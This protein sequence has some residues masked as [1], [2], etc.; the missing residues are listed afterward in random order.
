MA[1]NYNGTGKN[2]K[3]YRQDPS[4]GPPHPFKDLR[5]LLDFK[6]QQKEQEEQ[7][8]GPHTRANPPPADP[9]SLLRDK[10]RGDGP[11]VSQQKRN[12]APQRRG[13]RGR[14]SFRRRGGYGPRYMQGGSDYHQQEKFLTYNIKVELSTETGQR[15]Y[16]LGDIN[17]T[18]QSNE[19]NTPGTQNINRENAYQ[20]QN[21]RGYSRNRGG[22]RGPRRGQGSY[23]GVYYYRGQNRKYTPKN[24]QTDTSEA[25]SKTDNERMTNRP[26]TTVPPE[27]YEEENWDNDDVAVKNVN[28]SSNCT[29]KDDNSKKK[30]CVDKSE[31]EYIEGQEEYSSQEGQYLDDQEYVEGQGEYTSEDGQY[32]DGQGYPEGE[33]EGEIYYEDEY[34]TDGNYYEESENISKTDDRPDDSKKKENENEDSK[35][36][37]T[38]TKDNDK[39]DV[40]KQLEKNDTDSKIKQNIANQAV[41]EPAGNSKSKNVNDQG[42]LASKTQTGNTPNI[43]N[44]D[45]KQNSETKGVGNDDTILKV[46]DTNKSSS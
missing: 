42:K 17:P 20:F 15:K 27:L 19:N 35:D 36:T 2:G 40:D 45:D 23:R 5:E 32:I 6:K 21:K 38:V 33:G 44:D 34:G 13:S 30:E 39:A 10:L 3:R 18:S 16:T 37:N 8:G 22:Y 1:D 25:A 26:T 41:N 31:E 7:E 46:E 43:S 29:N 14:G 28:E 9:P 24:Q 11:F 12:D 4:K